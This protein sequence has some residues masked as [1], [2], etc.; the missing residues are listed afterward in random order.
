M[1]RIFL[2]FPLC[3]AFSACGRFE[4]AF[5][6]LRESPKQ[7][8]LL[9]TYVIQRGSSVLPSAYTDLTGSITLNAD[10]GLVI[11]NVPDCF[12]FGDREYFGGYYSGQ[13]TWKVRPDHSVYQVRLRL[14][15]MTRREFEKKALPQRADDIGVMIAKDGDTYALAVPLFDGDFSYVYLS[16]KKG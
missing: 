16:K 8:V 12:I 11:S 9:G 6:F 1:K 3:A 10:G 5:T 7:E 4:G 14:G 13:G 2:L 15:S